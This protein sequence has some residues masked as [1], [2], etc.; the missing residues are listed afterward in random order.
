MLELAPIA[1]HADNFFG[2]PEFTVLAE[3]NR[4]SIALFGG[5]GTGKLSPGSVCAKVEE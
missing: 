4:K 3:A 5:V 1:T 2:E